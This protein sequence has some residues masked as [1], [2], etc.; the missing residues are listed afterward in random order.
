[1]TQFAELCELVAGH[2]EIGGF[3]Q[4]ASQIRAL[5]ATARAVSLPT[6]E[7]EAALE[8]IRVRCHMKW[9]RDLYLAH[10]SRSLWWSTLERLGEAARKTKQTNMRG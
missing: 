6:A 7:R 1:M 4:E 10:V 5:S 8:Q 3:P 9:F 2:L